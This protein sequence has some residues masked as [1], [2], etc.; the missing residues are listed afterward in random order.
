MRIYQGPGPLDDFKTEPRLLNCECK[1]AAMM[2][3]ARTWWI[4]MERGSFR[5]MVRA[6]DR[7]TAARFVA[8]GVRP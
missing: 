5:G 3:T 8:L 4:L 1:R 7:S 2:N 6:R